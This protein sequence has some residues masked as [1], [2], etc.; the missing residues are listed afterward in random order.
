MFLYAHQLQQICWQCER[1]NKIVVSIESKQIPTN[2]LFAIA[3]RPITL[4]ISMETLGC[5]LIIYRTFTIT[6]PF[7][8]LY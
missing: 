5:K 4:M 3:N 2:M 1:S 8:H 7:L 6:F